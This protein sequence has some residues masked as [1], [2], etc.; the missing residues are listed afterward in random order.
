VYHYGSLVGAL[1]YLATCTRPDISYAAGMLCRFLSCPT[2]EHWKAATHL[3]HYL[4]GSSSKGLLYNGQLGLQQR[5]FCDA[6]YAGD[7]GSR[8]STSGAV[9]VLA[10]AAVIWS[11]RLQKCVTLSTCEAEYVAASAAARDAIWFDKLLF[12]M[13]IR[14]NTV[15][16]YGDNQ[17]ALKLIRNPIT[18]M[19][20]K[21]IDVHY[22][23]VREQAAIGRI[24]IGYISTDKMV[25]DALTKCVPESKHTFCC[26]AMGLC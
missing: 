7:K 12:E 23:F 22:H 5:G 25:A 1:N 21:H 8:R 9:F 18:S 2:K 24:N 3:L 19:R 17:G 16:L 10:G 6:D 20:S 13:G 26:A 11:S 15:Q 14:T 4:K